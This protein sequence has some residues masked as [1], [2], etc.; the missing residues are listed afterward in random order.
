MFLLLQ[1]YVTIS[2][3]MLQVASLLSG[4]CICSTH[5]LQLYVANVSF[6]S[7]CCIQVF[8][9]TSVSCFRGMFKESWGHDPDVGARG[10]AS[11]GAGRWGPLHT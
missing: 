9:I 7:D 10:V 2:V 1:S 11:Q 8:H 6:A 4:C 3:F 5:I